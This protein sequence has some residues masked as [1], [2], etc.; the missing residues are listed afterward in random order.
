MYIM[1]IYIPRISAENHTDVLHRF[2]LADPFEC[3]LIKV[4]YSFRTKTILMVF[5]NKEH[6]FYC[7]E[8]DNPF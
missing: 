2:P 4:I 1:Y 5:E 6:L 3:D 7:C 8:R